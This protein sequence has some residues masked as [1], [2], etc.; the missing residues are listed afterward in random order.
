[1]YWSGN[2]RIAAENCGKPCNFCSNMR[3]I[4]I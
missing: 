1:M 2:D 3:I 4:R